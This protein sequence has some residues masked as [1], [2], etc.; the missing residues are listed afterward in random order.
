MS[1]DTVHSIVKQSTEHYFTRRLDEFKEAARILK[2]L[3]YHLYRLKYLD[4][5]GCYGWLP[6]LAW[7]ELGRIR[8]L[9]NPTDAYRRE[10]SIDHDQTTYCPPFE[11]PLNDGWSSVTEINVKQ[12]W[13]IPNDY[14]LVLRQPAGFIA[15]ELLAHLYTAQVPA[16]V[17]AMDASQISANRT[18]RAQLRVTQKDLEV[19]KWIENEKQIRFVVTRIRMLRA[20]AKKGRIEF[21]HGL[22][23]NKEEMVETTYEGVN[24]PR[25]FFDDISSRRYNLYANFSHHPSWQRMGYY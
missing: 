23:S 15:R 9:E 11:P 4:L 24:A 3:C 6:A 14:R 19:M 5:E 2:H 16:D 13:W 21:S 18:Q 25:E 12:G 22:T 8:P 20:E 17:A 10:W 7:K 1:F